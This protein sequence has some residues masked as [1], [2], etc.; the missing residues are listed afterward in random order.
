MKIGAVLMLVELSDLGRALTFSEIRDAALQCEALG[1]DSIWIYD[2]LLYR[3]KKGPTTGIWEG[4]SIL[5]ADRFRPG[6]HGRR[7]G[8]LDL[9]R[10]D[11]GHAGLHVP[12]AG[13]R[14]ED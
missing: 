5:P 13:I 4:W 14:L 12:R 11:H 3:A 10:D 1:L 7:L 9:H 2:H 6:A 8:Q